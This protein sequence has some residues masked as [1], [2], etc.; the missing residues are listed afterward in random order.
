MF[1]TTS[2]STQYAPP[3]IPFVIFLF[4]LNVSMRIHV[5]IFLIHSANIIQ[6]FSAFLSFHFSY[7][8]CQ[9]SLFSPY[10]QYIRYSLHFSSPGFSFRLPSFLQI[11]SRFNYISFFLYDNHS[12]G[13]SSFS[14]S[15]SLLLH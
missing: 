12:S 13:L 3:V 1:C 9:F 14:L 15:F 5:F 10:N 11:N 8:S 4:L 2:T 6:F 7:S